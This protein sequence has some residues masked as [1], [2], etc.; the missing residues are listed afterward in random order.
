MNQQLLDKGAIDA[1]RRI[2][3]NKKENNTTIDLDLMDALCATADAYHDSQAEVA[4]LKPIAEEVEKLRV[5]ES[6]YENMKTRLKRRVEGAD[7]CLGIIKGLELFYKGTNHAPVH[8]LLKALEGTL[9][10]MK[11]HSPLLE[12]EDKV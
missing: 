8:H 9:L 10:Q 7:A 1:C 5:V 4:R 6:I 12:F 2:G 3:R 11:V